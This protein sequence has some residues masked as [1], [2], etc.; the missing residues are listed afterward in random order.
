[1]KF[2]NTCCTEPT[3]YHCDNMSTISIAHNPVHHDRTKYIE[4]D[5]HSI[6]YIIYMVVKIKILI[7]I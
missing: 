4:I 1:M 7:K 2:V 5:K 3:N 6:R